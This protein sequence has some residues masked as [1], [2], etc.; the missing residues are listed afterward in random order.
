MWPSRHLIRVMRRH[1]LTKLNLPTYIPNYLSTSR[2]TTNTNTAVQCSALFGHWSLWWFSGRVT[3]LLPLSLHKCTAVKYSAPKCT[4]VHQQRQI[5]IRTNTKTRILP[6][7]LRKCI[8]VSWTA[9]H[10]LVHCTAVHRMCTA[11][12]YNSLEYI[13]IHFGALHMLP[14]T[15]L[16]YCLKTKKDTEFY[17][18]TSPKPNDL[19]WYHILTSVFVCVDLCVWIFV[20]VY[21]CVCVSMCV[22]VFLC[23]FV[24]T[25]TCMC[26]CECV[27]KHISEKERLL[28]LVCK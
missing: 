9:I 7:S 6:L 17:L 1:D 23:L 27:D 22:F 18:K 28:M 14:C 12:K 16:H 24:C 21:V 2:G 25:T 11:L 26:V 15:A 19:W 8:A 20:C 3:C 5:Q 13:V 4:A 10:F